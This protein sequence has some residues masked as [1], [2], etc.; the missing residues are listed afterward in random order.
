MSMGCTVSVDL[1]RI[2]RKHGVPETVL[3]A[4]PLRSCRRARLFPPLAGEEERSS[5]TPV[6]ERAPSS[7]PPPHQ[8][9]PQTRPRSRS[10]GHEER[11]RSGTCESCIILR[12]FAKR[13]S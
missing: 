1:E 10:H 4:Q 8:R 7:P 2:K 12:F 5:L 9:H 6:I 11:A 3:G 13:R